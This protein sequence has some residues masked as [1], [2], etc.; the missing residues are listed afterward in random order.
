MAEE[1]EAVAA[2]MLG[3]APLSIQAVGGGGNNRLCR[4][5][6]RSATVALKGYR[7]ADG[8]SRDRLGQEWAALS[9][10]HPAL[11]A[12]VPR[13]IALDRSSGWAAYEW[14]EGERPATRDMAD[15]DAAVAFLGE[16]QRLR[17]AAGDLALASEACLSVG[18]LSAQIRRRLDRLAGIESLAPLLEALNATLAAIGATGPELPRSRQILSPSDFGF[19]N[20]LRR[21]DGRL[22]FLD[23]EYFGWDDPAKLASDIYWHPGMALSAA[24]RR[25]FDD[26]MLR[27]VGDDTDYP[28]RLRRFRPLIGLRWCLILLNEFLPQGLARRRHAGQGED[29]EAARAR[30]LAKARA[31]Y[32]EVLQGL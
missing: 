16:V 9:L 19:H 10:I 30:Q 24:E 21:P 2:R 22:V 13:P 28:A 25:R 23:F 4:V 14:I 5:E 7:V 17:P 31:L 15:I 1:I 26:G 3:E 8:D 29:A 11:P 6:T 20:T 18:E 12:S 27:L 32:S